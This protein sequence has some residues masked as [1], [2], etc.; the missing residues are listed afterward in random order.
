LKED[1][2]LKKF[3]KNII[4]KVEK[5]RKTSFWDWNPR[6][7]INNILI[8]NLQKMRLKNFEKFQVKKFESLKG[9]LHL[10]IKK[11]T[12]KKFSKSKTTSV[13]STAELGKR[14]GVKMKSIMRK[15]KNPVI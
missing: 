4:Q 7:K 13:S 15:K 10:K 2:A 6:S 8:D 1:A 14:R 3:K 11:K 12:R 9:K 5:K